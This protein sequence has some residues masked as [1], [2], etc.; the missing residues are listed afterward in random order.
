MKANKTM[1]GQAAPNHKER[2]KKVKSN[3]DPAAHSQTLE[4]QKYLN[5]RN[6]H[7]VLLLINTHTEC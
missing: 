6:H 3:I 1:K 7:I 4:Q 5:D 2:S